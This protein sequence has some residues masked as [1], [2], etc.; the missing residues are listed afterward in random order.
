[1]HNFTMNIYYVDLFELIKKAQIAL[2]SERNE[3]SKAQI[4]ALPI[5]SLSN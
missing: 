4:A 5:E 3:P 2:I 1:M